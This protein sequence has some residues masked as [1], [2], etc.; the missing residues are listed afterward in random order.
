[1]EVYA[2]MTLNDDGK[3]LTSVTW[4]KHFYITKEIAFEEAAKQENT[5]VVVL[6]Q[7]D[8]YPPDQVKKLMNLRSNIEMLKNQID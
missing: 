8:Y 7:T 5:S 4:H 3:G 1:M 6:S 2:L